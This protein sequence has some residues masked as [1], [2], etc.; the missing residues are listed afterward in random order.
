MHADEHSQ[1]IEGYNIDHRDVV[2][3]LCADR[4][5][6]LVAAVAA[7][8]LLERGSA[9]FRIEQMKGSQRRLVCILKRVLVKYPQVEREPKQ[10]HPLLPVSVAPLASEHDLHKVN[11][12]WVCLKCG[13]LPPPSGKA[14]AAYLCGT[15]FNR[16]RLAR[17]ELTRTINL[18]GTISIPSGVVIRV[19]GARVH[20]THSIWVREG[21]FFCVVCGIYA[22]RKVKGLADVCRRV[23]SSQGSANLKRFAEGMLPTMSW[24]LTI[25]LSTWI[26]NRASPSWIV[27]H[28]S[29]PYF[30]QG[31]S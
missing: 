7:V 17:F 12:K 20:R 24:P 11:G 15:C 21:V 31:A 14:L 8:P 27:L 6:G 25:G 5:A 10:K 28:W 19:A 4:F 13:M 9:L 30:T 18:P 22:A 23:P 16:L 3:N 2:G 1:F 29:A 26:C